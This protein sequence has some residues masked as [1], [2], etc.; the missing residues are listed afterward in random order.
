MPRKAKGMTLLTIHRPTDLLDSGVGPAGGWSSRSAPSWGP[1]RPL[2][3]PAL[4][5]MRA[6]ALWAK[7]QQGA[8][9]AAVVV[10]GQGRH[11]LHLMSR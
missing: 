4:V 5:N 6:T 8:S 10:V 11:V 9:E 3:A 1:P 2:R 7:V